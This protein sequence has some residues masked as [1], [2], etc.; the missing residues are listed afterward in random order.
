MTED[1]PNLIGGVL[2]SM[3]Q[4]MSRFVREEEGQD[5]VEYTLLLAFV[6]LASAALF[7]GAGKS[8]ANVWVDTNLIV[9]NA[10]QVANAV[11]AS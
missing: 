11:T 3:K 10:G 5:L 9:T 7:I 6:C 2:K 1:Q 8:M 4:L